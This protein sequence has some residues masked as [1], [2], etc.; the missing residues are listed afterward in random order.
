MKS[1]KAIDAGAEEFRKARTLLT[2][3]LERQLPAT[4]PV[5]EEAGDEPSS[6]D[7]DR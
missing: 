6:Y 7:S 5:E 4:L 2:Q 3:M 1:A